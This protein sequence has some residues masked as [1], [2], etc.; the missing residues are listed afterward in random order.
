MAPKPPGRFD[1][2]KGR[3]ELDGILPRPVAGQ[4]N[5]GD[6]AQCSGS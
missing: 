2:G 6:L 5:P 3:C 4:G 1:P